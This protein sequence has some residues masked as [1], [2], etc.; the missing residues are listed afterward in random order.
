MRRNI[1]I[2]RA[3]REAP[4]QAAFYPE[5]EYWKKQPGNRYTPEELREMDR[6]WQIHIANPDAPHSRAAD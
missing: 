1:T 2:F 6:H 4:L 3:E 5:K